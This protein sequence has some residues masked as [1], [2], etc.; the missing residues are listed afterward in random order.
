M[1]LH[2]Q[3]IT[4]DYGHVRALQGADLTLQ[5]GEVR[6]LLG[7]NGSG[8]STLTKVITG[9]TAADTG[10][11]EIDGEKVDISGPSTAARLGIA[12]TYQEVSL[13]GDLTVAENL[14]VR[15]IPTRLK[16]L[17]APSRERDAMSSA[18]DRVGLSAAVLGSY[19]RD[20][21][22]EQRSLVELARVLAA[23]PKYVV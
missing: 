16:L 9:V 11:I 22:L 8:K 2:V 14:C 12:A 15:R 23:R 7:G 10:T 19:V 21:D 20:L 18:L 3:N 6:A 13:A 1:A 4:K 17:S 5:P